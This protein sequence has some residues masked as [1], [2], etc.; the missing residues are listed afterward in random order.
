MRKPVEEIAH[1]L[2]ND[3]VTWKEIAKIVG[4]PASTLQVKVARFAA[5]EPQKKQKK[6]KTLEERFMT[7]VRKTRGCWLWTGS[8]VRGYGQLHHKDGNRPIRAHRASY[9]IHVGEIPLGM[10]VLHKCDNTACVN[11]KHLFLGDQAIN[12]Q[13]KQKKGRQLK[14]SDITGSKLTPKKVRAM[15][16]ER[17]AFNTSYAKLGE[18]Y[19]VHWVSARLVCI[20]RNWKH[21]V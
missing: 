9:I 10:H 11:P 6:K 2:R 15:R 8:K 3:G 14:G 21:V 1:G 17:K 12:M 20:R 19:G 5:G 7:K 16:K 18:K 4:V 13:D